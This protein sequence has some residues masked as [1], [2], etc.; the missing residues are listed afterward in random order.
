V[1][2]IRAAAR[3]GPVTLVY[4]ARD[5]AHKRAVVLRELLD[6]EAAER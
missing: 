5:E 2:E 3:D 4:A 6:R 1:E